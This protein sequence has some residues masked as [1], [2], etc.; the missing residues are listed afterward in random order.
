MQSTLMSMKKNRLFLLWYFTGEFLVA[1]LVVALQLKYSDWPQ[2]LLEPFFYQGLLLLP[3]GLVL[4]V[5]VPVWMH[6]SVHGNF[7]IPWV[8]RVVGELCG[9]A[10]M[11]GME[12]FAL[13]HLMHH[14]YPDS[15]LDPHNPNQ[16]KGN[17]FALSF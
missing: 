16:K 1:S 5:K 10:I 11:L 2:Y 15:D 8:N 17:L 9:V 4:G 12:A 14:A 7:R 13:N 3:L 6:N